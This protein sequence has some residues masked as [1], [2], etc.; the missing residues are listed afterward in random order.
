MS[1]PPSPQPRSVCR[2]C[3]RP[4][5]VCYCQYL[6]RIETETRIILLQHPRERDMPIGTARMASLCLPNSELLV[7][8]NWQS[9]RALA[10]LLSDPKRPAALLYP[11]QDARDVRSAPT[12]GP[13]TLV[14]VDGTWANTKKMVRRN[15]ILMNLPRVTFQPEHP[16][17]YRI[18]RE[19]DA[20]CVSTIE[21]LMYVL[22]A[23][24]G[25][26]S[27]FKRL[28]LPFQKMINTQLAYMSG[29]STP[30]DQQKRAFPDAGASQGEKA[31]RA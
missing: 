31:G 29:G 11:G 30:G 17:E 5:S 2:N 16:S 21:A 18:R 24:E 19:P 25:N 20:Q 10:R 23:I 9:S 13:L 4:K 7:G 22:G 6:T 27:R 26:A 12:H 1:E 28:Q 3:R 14:V 8:F 15:P